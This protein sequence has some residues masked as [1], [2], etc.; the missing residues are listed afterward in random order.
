MNVMHNKMK[1]SDFNFNLPT[2]LVAQYPTTFRDQSR[3][4]VLHRKT[5]AIEHKHFTD[6]LEY[7]GANDTFVLNDTKVFP[8]RLYGHKEK[9]QARIEVFLLRELNE[10]LRL[11]DVLVDPARKIRIGNKL[12]F[13]DEGGAPVL[14]AEVI[15]NTTSRGRTLR[16]LY[17][18][19]HED[20]I[21][22]L[23]GLGEAPLPP[24]I[25]RASEPEDLERYQTVYAK[26]IGAVCAPAAGCHFSEIL[27]HKLLLQDCHFAYLTLHHSLSSY[28]EIDVEDLSKYK[29]ENEEMYITQECCDIVNRAKDKNAQIIAVGASTMRA[30]EQG[31]ST[32]GY[33]KEF[34]GWTNK[35]LYPPFDIHLPT[36]MITNFNAP[37]SINLMCAVTMGGYD[38]VMN[39]Y[40]VAIEQE[41]RFGPYGDALLIID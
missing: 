33:L 5:G 23:Y 15:D 14:V 41:Y 17:D 11:W 2:E 6:L 12:E 20:F 16:F 35:F 27:M 13:G 3:M 38:N 28:R 25:N 29:V 31:V 24:E 36:A 34:E 8:A 19:E 26:N 10:S 4:M 9:T 30:I 18:G 39:A 37:K 7:F 22:E 32:D 40:K 21:K 1:L